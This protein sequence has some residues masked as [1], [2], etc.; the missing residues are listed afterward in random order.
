MI[1]SFILTILGYTILAVVSIFDK[2]ILTKSLRNPAVY[3]FYSTIFFIPLIILAPFCSSVTNADMLW[4]LASGITFGLGM[5]AMF[6]AFKQGEASHISPF[7]GAIVA[8]ATFAFSYFIL[9]SS[10]TTSEQFGL[11]LLV[12]G[13]LLL[14]FEKSHEHSG[15]HIGFIWGILSGILFGFSHVSSKYIYDIYP[16]ITGIV[17]TKSTIGIVG[18]ITFL[19]PSVRKQLFGKESSGNAEGAGSQTG[20][21][22]VVLDK[23]LSIAGVL[24]IQYA[25][26]IGNVTVVNA[27]AGLQYALLFVL[28]YLLTKLSPKLFSEYFTK[29][30]L[31]VQSL[32]ILLTLAGLIF[33]H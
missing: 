2:L 31:V 28:I 24:C 13:C 10:L 15:F 23:V 17:W 30:E 9:H 33:M 26:A 21:T 4:S 5:W 8:I 7:I 1:S 14:S 16:F 25:I 20:T 11:V 12:L 6:I 22:I 18:I 32:A 29:R 27:L 19:M 3:A